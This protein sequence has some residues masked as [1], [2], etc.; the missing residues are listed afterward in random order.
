MDVHEKLRLLYVACTRARDHLV[1]AVHHQKDDR[2]YACTV[3]T[4][5][6][7][8]PDTWRA[9]PAEEEDGPAA[10]TATVAVTSPALAD[11]P[12]TEAATASVPPDDDRE[13]WLA[14]REALLAPQRRPRFVAATTIAREAGAAAVEE[15]S[16]PDDPAGP[17]GITGDADLPVTPR[18]RGRAGTAIGRAVHATLQF[19]DLAA[20][21]GLEA[22]AARQ[23]DLE[24]VPE[25]AAVIAAMARSAL[26]SDA[27]QLAAKSVSHNEIYVAA[28]VGDR[29]IEGYIDLLIETPE[30]LVIVDYKTDTVASEADVDAKLAT[31]E[32]QGAAYAVALEES[33]G[34][35]VVD[36]RFV[37]CRPSGAI[38][39]RVVDL[40]A[41]KDRVRRQLERAER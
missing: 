9:L 32:L 23:A 36:C 30:G 5:T 25:H 3:W 35:P 11:K 17:G 39:R 12:S 37:F 31:Y 4:T 21:A 33:T 10:M 27:V 26:A 1:V 16:D 18:R 34:M 6:Q 13:A 38:E 41:A 14:A 24:A 8:E 20:P 7:S 28:P 2:S 15:E 40:D 22:Q 19:T 29:V